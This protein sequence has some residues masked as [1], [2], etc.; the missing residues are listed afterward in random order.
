MVKTT[1]SNNPN[2]MEYDGV[3]YISGN[4]TK[5]NGAN[6]F[7]NIKTKDSQSYVQNFFVRNYNN[8]VQCGFVTIPLN[9]GDSFYFNGNVNS[10]DVTKVRYYKNRDYSNR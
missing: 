9:K 2:I 10:I 3:V 5:S 7:I 4:A 1:D 6:I 8:I